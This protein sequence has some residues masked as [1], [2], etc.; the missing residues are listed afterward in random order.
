[1]L[2][3]I[4]VSNKALVIQ[5]LIESKIFEIRGKRVMLD[6]DLAELYGGETRVSNQA[7]RRNQ[8]RFPQDFMFKLS[9]EEKDL[10]FERSRSQSVILKRGKNIKYSP[11]AF[12]ENGVSMLSLVLNSD[13]AINVNILI[14]RTFT[15]LRELMVSNKKIAQQVSILEQ[16]TQKNEE[17]IKVIFNTMNQLISPEKHAILTL[18]KTNMKAVNQEIQEALSGLNRKPK[19]DITGSVQH[20]AAA[21][22]CVFRNITGDYNSTLGQ[23][24]KKRKDIIPA[25]L[26]AAIIKIWGYASDRAR[27]VREGRVLEYSEAEIVVTQFISLANFLIK[28]FGKK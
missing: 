10:W 15:K 1:M 25:P 2:E 22:E 8:K 18:S 24:L 26:D 14:M 23:I 28:K 3:K 17:D 13:R 9:E 6:R 16:T 19:P 11:Y 7:V 5:D 12:T 20:A 27:H 21:V 4:K